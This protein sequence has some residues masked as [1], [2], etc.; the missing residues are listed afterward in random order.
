MDWFFGFAKG[1]FKRFLHPLWIANKTIVHWRFFF[2]SH[3]SFRYLYQLLCKRKIV[4]TLKRKNESVVD[5]VFYITGDISVFIYPKAITGELMNYKVYQNEVRH[6]VQF[7]S[8]LPLIVG[9]LVGHVLW[10][11]S[12]WRYID[13]I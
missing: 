11:R 1:I 12:L 6:H 9:S 10:I 5:S 4:F 13:L 2:Q 8:T 3:R 7:I